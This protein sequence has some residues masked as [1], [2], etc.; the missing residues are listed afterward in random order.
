LSGPK[1]DRFR[2]LAATRVNLSPVLL[3]YDD[4][5]N[6]AASAAALDL[7]T[8]AAPTATAVGPGGVGQRLWAVDPA[9]VPAARALLDLA[10]RNPLTIADGHH[11]YETALR[12]RATSGAAPE[13][14][15]V[16]ALLYDAHSGGIEVRPWHRV[17][18]G[19]LARTAID[20]VDVRDADDLVAQLRDA[21][22]TATP[23][24]FGVWTRA[25]GKLAQIEPSRAGELD[26][27]ILSDTL[28]QMSGATTDELNASGRLSY[29]SDAAAAIAAVEAGDA[30]VCFLVRP[31]P[32]ESVLS[33][34]AAGGFMPPKSTY[35]HPKAA[36]GLVFNPL[37]Q[38]A[39]R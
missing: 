18:S 33:M 4:A 17:I 22:G 3:L 10:G 15:H 6:G 16:L 12:Y 14:D 26:V 29:T 38:A 21:D 13:A 24:I 7:L 11:R 9:R 35:F 8:T 20:G 23:G 30:S 36:T 2:L 37:W 1:E 32:V 19:P 27:D 39:T 34:A 28:P 25:G 5:A 31:T